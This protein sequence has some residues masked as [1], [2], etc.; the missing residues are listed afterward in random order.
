MRFI[1]RDLSAQEVE[2]KPWISNKYLYWIWNPLYS[3]IQQPEA[4]DNVYINWRREPP[5]ETFESNEVSIPFLTRFFSLWLGLIQLNSTLDLL[6]F[7]IKS[8]IRFIP[9]SK[10]FQILMHCGIEK[11][12]NYMHCGIHFA[13]FNLTMYQ[14]CD[15]GALQEGRL[16]WPGHGRSNIL[17]KKRERRRKSKEVKKKRKCKWINQ[18]VILCFICVGLFI[19]VFKSSF[20][21]SKQIESSVSDSF[22]GIWKWLK[23]QSFGGT[24]SWIP[25][26]GFS[27]DPTRALKRARGP[28]AI[29]HSTHFARYA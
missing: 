9:I 5:W 18:L 3:V 2:G 10:I 21:I 17:L 15:T 29:R 20:P 12:A 11:S 13:L 4:Q 8:S 25:D 27:C 7:L 14:A 19:T 6:K 16:G 28:Y 1:L 26:R 24:A 23:P 22:L